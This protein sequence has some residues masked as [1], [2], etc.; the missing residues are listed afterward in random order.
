MIAVRMMKVAIDE[1]V[2]VIAM[3]HGFMPA[4]RSMDV[5]RR[6][7]GAAVFRRAAIGILGADCNHM[8]VDMIG[9]RM[10]QMSVVEIIDMTVMADGDVAAIWPM[11]M[12]VIGVDGV[13]LGG[14]GSFLRE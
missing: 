2:D 14:H 12:R 1:I 3:R 8:F 7:T 9:M 5:A 6:V 10:M 13:I 11:H 4:P